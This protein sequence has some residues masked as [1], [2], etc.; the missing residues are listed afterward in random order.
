MFAFGSG[1]DPPFALHAET[2]NNN[3]AIPNRAI[4]RAMMSFLLSWPLR[5]R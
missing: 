3:E 1:D 4:T 5:A 2:P